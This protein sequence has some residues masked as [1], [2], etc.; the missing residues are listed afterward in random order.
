MEKTHTQEW[1]KRRQER[2]DAVLQKSGEKKPESYFY[3][4]HLARD[5]KRL[6]LMHQLHDLAARYQARYDNAGLFNYPSTPATEWIMANANPQQ[7]QTLN[8]LFE[9]DPWTQM[10][11]RLGVVPHKE[12]FLYDTIK[13]YADK[14][15]SLQ[16]YVLANAA[17]LGQTKLCAKILSE[18]W[19]DV[20]EAKENDQTALELALKRK[21]LKTAELLFLRGAEIKRKDIDTDPVI[22]ACM[23]GDIHAL[24][25]FQKYNVD[26]KTPFV[27]KNKKNKKKK[28][29]SLDLTIYSKH[30]KCTE[31]LLAAGVNPDEKTMFFDLNLRDGVQDE[32]W[33]QKNIGEENR[34]LLQNY[35][36]EHPLP[37]RK[38]FSLFRR[39]F[40]KTR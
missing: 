19:I 24:K 34:V 14:L 35:F 15:K 5:L 18:S 39:V 21:R 8:Q 33:S 25:L 13:M 17:A 16:E 23:N 1:E 40:S 32:E 29:S 28:F 27:Y 26:L 31:V 7:I 3:R 2:I 22:R 36:K 11:Q 20:N 30:P 10:C 37:V 38:R 9:L 4:Q 12:S 6:E